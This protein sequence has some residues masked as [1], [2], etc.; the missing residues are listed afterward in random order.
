MAKS[1]EQFR[2]DIK[3]LRKDIEKVAIPTIRGFTAEV[4]KRARKDYRSRSL[5]RALWG[6]GRK[7]T[8][9]H[10]PLVLK[11]IPARLSA[12]SGGFIGGLRVKGIAALIETGGSIERHRIKGNPFLYFESKGKLVRARV[13]RHPGAK[14]KQIA[15]VQGGLSRVSPIVERIMRHNLEKLFERVAL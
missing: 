8:A 15:S 7:K 1:I 11:T 2:K 4:R 3:I 12:S 6:R 5:G 10:P 13:V 14:V 9:T